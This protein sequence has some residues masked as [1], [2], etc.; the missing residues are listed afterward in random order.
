MTSN[1]CCTPPSL[2]REA[3]RRSKPSRILTRYIAIWS[4]CLPGCNSA[5]L[6]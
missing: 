1:L 5:R 2:C 6:A 3:A 4:S